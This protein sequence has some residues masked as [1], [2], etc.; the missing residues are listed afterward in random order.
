MSAFS[1]YQVAYD[2]AFRFEGIISFLRIDGDDDVANSFTTPTSEEG[3]WD[4][5]AAV[6]TLIN[7]LTTCPE[8][9]EER[10]QLRDEFSRRGLNEIIV[11]SR[12]YIELKR[13]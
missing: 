13:S 11:V 6:L 4:A 1:D 12:T 2:E 3:A 5:R 9:L 10:I 7:A 8:S